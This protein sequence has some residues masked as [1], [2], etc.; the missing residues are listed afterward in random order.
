VDA[1]GA[2]NLKQAI[3]CKRQLVQ[4]ATRRA[5]NTGPIGFIKQID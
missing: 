3:F 4:N 2:G 1:D 5:K